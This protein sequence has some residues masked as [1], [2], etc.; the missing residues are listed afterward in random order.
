M[1]PELRTEQVGECIVD[2]HE[3]EWEKDNFR[4]PLTGSH[5]RKVDQ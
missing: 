2:P 5:V 3:Q 4:H 1:F